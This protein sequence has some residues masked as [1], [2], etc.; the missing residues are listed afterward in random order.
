[1]QYNL[2][3][4]LAASVGLVSAALPKA[5]EYKSLDWYVC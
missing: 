5:N 2:I 4:T 3:L 1:M